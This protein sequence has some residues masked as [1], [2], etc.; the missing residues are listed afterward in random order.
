MKFDCWVQKHQRLPLTL[1]MW[2]IQ[3]LASSVWALKGKPYREGWS[4]SQRGFQVWSLKI[5]FWSNR[6]KKSFFFKSYSNRK[7]E[8]YL[9]FY[10]IQSEITVKG[11]VIEECSLASI[12]VGIFTL[13]FKGKISVQSLHFSSLK[14][15]KSDIFTR[16]QIDNV[17]K[18]NNEIEQTLMSKIKMRLLFTLRF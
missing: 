14:I 18:W 1:L 4:F 13:G 11:S 6:W 12:G 9:I 15:R 3:R 7:S 5:W 8:L 10:S 16:F 17:Y 2:L